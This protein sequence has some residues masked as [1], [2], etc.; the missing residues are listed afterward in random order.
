LSGDVFHSTPQVRE[1]RAFFDAHA[2][3]IPDSIAEEV[4]DNGQIVTATVPVEEAK[5]EVAAEEQEEAKS[6][7]EVLK[8]GG[9]LKVSGQGHCPFDFAFPFTFAP[10]NSS[11]KLSLSPFLSHQLTLPLPFHFGLL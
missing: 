8:A 6:L 9:I 4:I 11:L 2:Q 10:V 1:L 3:A 7:S 5:D